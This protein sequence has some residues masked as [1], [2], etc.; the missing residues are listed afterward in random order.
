MIGRLLGDRRRIEALRRLD[1]P[2]AAALAVVQA[3]VAA[4]GWFVDPVWLAVAVAVQLML[5]SIGAV[6]V[7]GPARSDLGLARYAVPAMAGIAATLFGRLIPGG[8]SLLLVPIVAVLLWS[9]TYLEVRAEREAGGRTM[10][11]LLLMLIVVAGTAG[12]FELF[13]I[14]TWPT[15]MALVA[16]LVLPAA[17]RSAEL[18]GT[19]GAE[20]L[21]QAL[22]HVLAVVQVGVAAVLLDMTVVATSALVGLGF[23]TWAGAADALNQGSSG[24]SVAVEFGALVLIGLFVGLVLARG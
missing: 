1:R 20:G 21:G 15:P 7:M 14:A 6:R 23:Y 19:H 10:R 17:V 13:G 12:L 3:I 24:R 5:G 4:V 11:D 2:A 16:L 9:V 18:R 22:V 8:L